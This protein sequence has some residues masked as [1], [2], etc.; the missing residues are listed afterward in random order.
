MAAAFVY[1]TKTLNDNWYEDRCQPPGGLTAVGDTN[2]KVVRKYETDIAYVGERYDVLTRI[3]RVPKRA[4]YAT[5]EDG[6][7]ETA[8]TSS[9]DFAPPRSRKEFVANAPPKARFITT[10]TIPEVCSEERRPV[11]GPTR[12]FGGVLDR[13]GDDHGLRCWNT[14][15]GEAFG[16]RPNGTLRMSRSD[17]GLRLSASGSYDQDRNTG[18]KVGNLCGEEFRNTGNPTND[19]MTQRAWV[20]DA[21]LGN[22]H[23]GGT[24]AKVRGADNHLSVPIG[25]GAMAKI[26]KDLADRQGRLFRVATTI[27][28]GRDKRPG[29]AL[30]KDDP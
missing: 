6:F 15:S 19:T 13:H 17:P 7:R 21:A 4:S 10:E 22:I 11:P 29:V 26:K 5:P 9:I 25:D 12:G 16:H 28:K 2:S 8:R 14:S 30:F 23:H 27:T 24:R 18:M 1:S 3:G 20:Y